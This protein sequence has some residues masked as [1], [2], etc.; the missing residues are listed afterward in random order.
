M[1]Q[2][3]QQVLNVHWD[4]YLSL[5][6]LW[7]RDHPPWVNIFEL[8]HVHAHKLIVDVALQ[9]LYSVDDITCIKF[10]NPLSEGICTQLDFLV[11]VR[12]LGNLRQ[13]HHLHAKL[14]FHDGKQLS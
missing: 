14:A 5:S 4:Q 8:N 2:L 6:V 9:R 10:A 11:K 3:V 1:K 12:A 7:V 13:V